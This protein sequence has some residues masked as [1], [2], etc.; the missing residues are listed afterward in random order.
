MLNF[1]KYNNIASGIAANEKV[2]DEE[3]LYIIIN[4]TPDIGQSTN[5]SAR[6]KHYFNISYLTSKKQLIISRTLLKYGSSGFSLEILEYCEKSAL[7]KREQYYLDKFNPPYNILKI[8][9]SSLPQR[10]PLPLKG[11]GGF[12]QSEE[13]KAKISKS[14]KGIY[15]G[16]NSALFGRVHSEET[17]ALMSI[18]KLG[19][20][21]QN[22]GKTHSEKTKELIRQRAQGRILSEETK[23]LMSQKHGNPVNVYEKASG[24]FSLIGSFVSIRKAAQFLGISAGTVTRHMQSG[25]LFKDKYKFST[26]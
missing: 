21:N 20:K 26:R 6:F 11:G 19:D 13:T 4:Y 10:G 8:A 22:F 16:E 25:K 2:S 18:K 24:K 15:T 12:K 5:L 3:P 14:L 7:L 17:K 1:N 9:G 23:A